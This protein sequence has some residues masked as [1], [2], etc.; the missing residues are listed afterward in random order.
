MT[1]N[2]ERYSRLSLDDELLPV[3]WRNDPT[4]VWMGPRQYDLPAH[5]SFTHYVCLRVKGD[6]GPSHLQRYYQ[7]L[8]LQA[9]SNRD[10]YNDL[11]NLYG[12]TLV[13]NCHTGMI[14]HTEVLQVISEEIAASYQ[15]ELSR[16]EG[17]RGLE[18]RELAQALTTKRR[19]EDLRIFQSNMSDYITDIATFPPNYADEME[20]KAAITSLQNVLKS[21]I[22]PHI[23]S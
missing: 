23:D 12:K 18:E 20:R 3:D 21:G 1:G 5:P 16:K 4:Y 15:A 6:T 9:Q 14:C 2:K 11:L 19:A 10:L 8:V 7:E 13:C 22:T 17:I